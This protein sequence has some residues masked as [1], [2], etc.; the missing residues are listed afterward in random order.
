MTMAI[1]GKIIFYYFVQLVD[2][3]IKYISSNDNKLKVVVKKILK[4]LSDNI[5]FI[6]DVTNMINNVY[7]EARDASIPLT[8]T[9]FDQHNNKH[10]FVSE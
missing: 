10:E 6:E 1:I 2:K 7:I 4:E 3:G 5:S 8:N 9:G